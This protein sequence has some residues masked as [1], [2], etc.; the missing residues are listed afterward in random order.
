[1]K[2]GYRKFKYLTWALF[3]STGWPY[4][5]GKIPAGIPA[6]MGMF[7]GFCFKP[8]LVPKELL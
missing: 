6:G 1:M 8:S 5:V 4:N 7:F 2:A 3:I